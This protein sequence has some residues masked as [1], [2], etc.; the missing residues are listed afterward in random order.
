MKGK[1]AF[2]AGA[3][4]GFLLGSRAGREPYEKAK[5]QARNMWEK[6]AVQERVSAAG[7]AVREQGSQVAG[8]VKD[9]FGSESSSG[10]DEVQAPSDPYPPPP[11]RDQ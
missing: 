3:A 11:R 9:R 8:K 2:V 1:V 4:V 5:E 7:D 10:A 6:P